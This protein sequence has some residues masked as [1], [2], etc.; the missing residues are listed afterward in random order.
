MRGSK[1]ERP[2]AAPLAPKSNP[3]IELVALQ[4]LTENAAPVGNSRLV[5][6]LQKVGIAVAEATAGRALSRLVSQGSARTLGKRG[7]VVTAAGRAKLAGL[8]REMLHRQRS[9][10]LVDVA[11][12]GNVESLRDMLIVRRAI[13]PEA[14]RLAASRA[15]KE[16]IAL[17]EKYACAHCS[18]PMQDSQRVDPAISFHSQLVRASHHQFLIEL[19]LL[20]LEHNDTLLL[21]K[22]S[23]DPKLAR[24][25]ERVTKRDADAFAK[26]HE[27]IVDAIKRRDPVAAERIMRKHIDRLLLKATTYRTSL[28]PKAK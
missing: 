18:A 22:I 28:E 3:T 20:T 13:E 21:D 19:G 4:L 26:D 15:S 12:I 6:A 23:H 7:R 24:Q 14:A 16:D 27:L 2:R 17:L 10:R 9:A 8:Q 1:K 25:T 5:E 11:N